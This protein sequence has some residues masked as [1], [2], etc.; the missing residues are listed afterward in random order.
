MN[1]AEWGSVSPLHVEG[2]HLVDK[3]GKQVM[4]HGVMDTPSPYFSGYRWTDGHGV[5][6]YKDGDNWITNCKNYFTELFDAVTDRSQGSWCNVFRLHLDPCWTNN[7][8]KPLTGSDTGEANISQ[9]DGTRLDKYLTSLFVPIAV[10]AKNHGMYVIM[11]PP[12]VC[13][14]TIK[15]G[16]EYQKYLLDVWSRVTS[17]RTVNR[18]GNATN[19]WLSIELANEPV[20]IVDENGV[21]TEQAMRDFFQPIVDKIRKNGFKGIIWVPGKTWQQ[22]YKGYARYPV[23]D[24]M[25]ETDGQSNLGYAAHFY[26]GWFSTGNAT[27]D[28][29]SVIRSFYDMVPVIKDYPIMITEVDW[30]PENPGATGHYNE[31]GQWVIPNYGTWATGTTSKFGVAFKKF[32]E[33]FGNVGMTLTHTHDYIDI[34]YYRSTKKVR[35]AFQVAMGGNAYEAC[36][37]A[38]FQWYPQFAA[39]EIKAYD[40]SD[41]G[42]TDSYFPLYT[43]SNN[44]LSYVLNPSIWTSGSFNA[45]TGQLTTGQYGFGGWKYTGGIDLSAYKYIVIK[46][47]KTSSSSASFRLFDKDDYWAKPYMTAAGNRTKVIVPLQGKKNDDGTTFDPSHIYIA[48]FWTNGGAAQSVYI[49]E[50]FVSNDGVN[51][52]DFGDANG[53]GKIT[54]EDA[55]IIRDYY[56]GKNPAGIR[57][58]SADVDGDS[59]VTMNDANIII[60]L[61]LGK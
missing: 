4:L 19:G 6:L 14:K 39:K 51:P 44:P 60:K 45:S 49:D 43:T 53:D 23:I 10:S 3:D 46:F 26:P 22:N 47:K 25:K 50:I 12:G 54:M 57:M 33:F 5:D 58:K 40:W 61:F 52:A 27:F 34:D 35:P 48:G 32:L 42:G 29:N 20:E 37:G 28:G 17:N 16:G 31:S 7:T 21:A 38:C 41:V 9:Y 1:A 24:P 55:Y 36:S 11:R 18:Y 13:P 15:V 2:N 56:L 8:S 30:S 59:K